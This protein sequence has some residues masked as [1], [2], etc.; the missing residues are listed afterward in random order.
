MEKNFDEQPDQKEHGIISIVQSPKKE[1]NKS[2]KSNNTKLSKPK[3]HG[4]ISTV[5]S[6]DQEKKEETGK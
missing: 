6:T 4:I 1:K 3:K 5:Q 2:A